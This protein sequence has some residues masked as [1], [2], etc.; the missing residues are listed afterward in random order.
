MSAV[1]FLFFFWPFFQVHKCLCKNCLVHKSLDVDPETAVATPRSGSKNAA[2]VNI[3]IIIYPSG[4]EPARS[5]LEKGK[6]GGKKNLEDDWTFGHTGHIHHGQFSS[7][8]TARSDL[9]V[10]GLP[11]HLL[12][13]I[14][15]YAI[16]YIVFHFISFKYELLKLSCEVVATKS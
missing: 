8:A 13:L 14:Q 5:F 10:R 15:T 4:E 1:S 9:A 11:L 2:S 6:K 3:I 16:K 12:P 7:I